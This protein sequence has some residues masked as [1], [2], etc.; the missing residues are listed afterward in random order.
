MTSQEANLLV[1]A[2]FLVLSFVF[3]GLGAF[4]DEKGNKE[5]TTAFLAIAAV[6]LTMAAGGFIKWILGFIF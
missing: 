6:C 3:G 1:G 2:G 5:A 4:F